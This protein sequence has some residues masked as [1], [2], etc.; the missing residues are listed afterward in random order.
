MHNPRYLATYPSGHVDV[1]RLA[2]SCMR[3]MQLNIVKTGSR[4]WVDARQLRYQLFFRE[5]DL[6]LSVLDDGNEASARH[7]VAVVDGSVVGYGRLHAKTGSVFQISQM[8]VSPDH[9]GQGIGSAILRKLISLTRTCGASLI[10]LNARLPAVSF[11]AAE[12]FKTKGAPFISSTTK[13]PHIAMQAVVGH[14]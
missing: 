9:Q 8:V 3:S 1:N 5:H 13:V 11:Y 2:Q 10:T 14:A 12:G 6:P 4:E 7:L